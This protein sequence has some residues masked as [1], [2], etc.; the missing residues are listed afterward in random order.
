MWEQ[1]TLTAKI[2][3]TMKQTGGFFDSG[4]GLDLIFSCVPSG[5][6]GVNR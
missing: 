2:Q 1:Q 6:G 4:T 3:M 5:H